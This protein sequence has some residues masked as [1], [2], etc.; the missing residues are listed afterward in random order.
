MLGRVYGRVRRGLGE[1]REED[2][3][4][5]L[6]WEDVKEVLKGM[7]DKKAVGIDGI[8]AEVWKYGGK[9][10]ERWV[11]MICDR[12]WKGEGW[13]EEW[14][15]GIIVPIMKKGEGIN[16]EEYRGVLLTTALYKRQVSKPGGKIV[17]LFVDLRA[18]FD[19][20]D[21][22]TLVK[23]IRD[24]GVREGLVVR[25]EDVLREVRNRVRVGENL[26]ECFWTGRGVRQG[27]PLSPMLFNL[28]TAD[29]EQELR[30]GRW[31]GVR[32]GEGNIFSLAYADDMVLLAEK[33]DG[34][35]CML[36][37]LERYLDG[38]GL[39]LNVNKTRIMRFRKGGGRKRKMNWRWKEKVIEEVK[40]FSYL[41][42]VVQSNE[43]QK[44]YVKERMRRGAAVMGKVWG[45]GKWRFKSDWGR[46]CWLF[47]ALVWPVIGYGVEIWGWKERE[48]LERLQERYLKWVLGVEWSTLGY[49]IREEVQRGKLRER[50]GK[51]VLGFKLR[52]EEGRGSELARRGD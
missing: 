19:S 24:R 45:M 4:K 52:L 25:C 16:V 10:M 7:K 39:E 49:M 51:R 31:E 47:D 14:N 2:Q 46:R 48:S 26:G 23:S 27:C 36:A 9:E 40:E 3:E 18:A 20:V 33:E 8:P 6:R 17:A 42:Y 1:G 30:G 37:R 28:L 21:R 11:W 32:L 22:E 12:I 38:K 34:I 29:L 5:G 13:I 35:K 43:G 50:A 41:G 44:A 15:K